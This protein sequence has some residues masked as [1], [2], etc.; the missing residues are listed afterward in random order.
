MVGSPKRKR[1]K[2]GESDSWYKVGKEH[3]E[4][5]S[6]QPA[7]LVQKDGPPKYTLKGMPVDREQPVRSE[8]LQDGG[9]GEDDL[10]YLCCSICST[11]VAAC[12]F[13]SRFQNIK[14]HEASQLHQRAALKW[15]EIQDKRGVLQGYQDAAAQLTAQRRAGQTASLKTRTVFASVLKHMCLGRPITDVLADKEFLQFVEPA[16][17]VGVTESNRYS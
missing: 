14:F 1:V 16:P 6:M 15:Q 10:Y 5:T 2:Q 11:K 3:G 4:T 13:Q 12:K 7:W 9:L 8:W 17:S